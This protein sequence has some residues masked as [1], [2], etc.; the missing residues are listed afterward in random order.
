[1]CKC[2]TTGTVE[3][4]LGGHS[5]L[6]VHACAS[7]CVRVCEQTKNG[8]PVQTSDVVSACGTQ[9]EVV[10][11][12]PNLIRSGPNTTGSTDDRAS[13]HTS[14]RAHKTIM[15]RG[16]IKKTQRCIVCAEREEKGALREKE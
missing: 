7:L 9:E 10:A 3:R 4:A 13:M 1:M 5:V 8:R 11:H 2:E 12:G 6:G 16:S 14:T 15:K